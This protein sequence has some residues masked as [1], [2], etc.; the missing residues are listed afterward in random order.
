MENYREIER[1]NKVKFFLVVVEWLE[2]GLTSSEEESS[3]ED[4]IFQKRGSWKIEDRRRQSSQKTVGSETWSVKSAKSVVVAREADRWALLPRSPDIY[5][6]SHDRD[7]TLSRSLVRSYLRSIY[8]KSAC[9]MHDIN[10]ETEPR[11]PRRPYF[12]G[13]NKMNRKFLGDHLLNT[14]YNLRECSED[15]LNHSCFSRT[16]RAAAKCSICFECH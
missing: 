13:S 9:A 5:M 14:G 12:V 6:M 11:A 16:E 8:L 15:N 3:E 4:R 10:S 1:L 2:D 7:E